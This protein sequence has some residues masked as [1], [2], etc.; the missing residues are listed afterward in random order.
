MVA[1]AARQRTAASAEETRQEINA[2]RLLLPQVRRREA[3]IARHASQ[4]ARM[5]ARHRAHMHR[6]A[7]MA[8]RAALRA[9]GADPPS[10]VGRLVSIHNFGG[11]PASR[12]RVASS[13]VV[14]PTSAG[15]SGSMS[16]PAATQSGTPTDGSSPQD[17]TVVF[18]PTVA[19]ALVTIYQAYIQNPSD[20]TVPPSPDAA[21]QVL[22]QGSNVGIEVHVSNPADFDAVVAD[23][24][25]AGMQILAS[26]ATYDLIDGLLPIAQLPTVAQLPQMPS[27]GA[28][29]RP[30]AQ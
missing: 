9:A 14:A 20:F 17:T 18:P 5:E 6:L 23:L 7:M 25:N 12:V 16:S 28:M 1:A 3:A 10:R 15:G 11:S 27:I 24:Q 30:I 2:E 29:F 21:Q 13:P 22:I 8:A 26:S 4:I 19:P